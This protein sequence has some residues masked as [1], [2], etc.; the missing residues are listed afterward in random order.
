MIEKAKRIYHFFV[1]WLGAILYGH[2]SRNL[3][4]IGVTGTKGKSST[5]ELIA[6]IFRRSGIKT[7]SLSSAYMRIGDVAVASPS[8]NTMPGRFFIQRFLARARRQRCKAA[9]I[10]V[11]SQG[12]LQ[13]RARFIDFD[14]GLITNLHP[15]HIEAHGSYEKYRSAKVK[16]FKDVNL[17]SRKPDKHFFF[18]RNLHDQ[19]YFI[20]AVAAE[21]IIWYSRLDFIALHAKNRAE[22]NPWFLSD[23]NL[24]NAAAATAAAEYFSV[25]PTAVGATL[26]N[27]SGLAGRVEFIRGSVL[28]QGRR[29][30]R[31]AVIDSALTPDSLKA[32]YTFLKTQ[33]SK[34]GELMAVFGS[35]G[36]GRDKWK[37]PV[38]GKIAE[39]YCRKIYLTT[40]DPYNEDPKK[41]ALDIKKGINNSN[42]C[43]II[44]DRAQA[45]KTA[46][47][48]ATEKDI[49][50]ITGMGSQLYSYGRHGK[51]IPWSEKRATESI[52]TK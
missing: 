11:T 20:H 40:D 27:F 36:G 43:E 39:E 9:V 38:L 22:L 12:V 10:E 14:A 50:A 47:L 24:E 46:L 33:L 3:I 16:F 6:D 28:K 44:L 29:E 45:I 26:K 7:A 31:T 4:V 30:L 8:R 18:N 2:P 34:G 25:K 1:S 21:N 48:E 37:R 13:W 35:A 32:L 15:E 49:V 23:F 42:K 19:N 41:I 17:Y 51:K 5:V 52:L